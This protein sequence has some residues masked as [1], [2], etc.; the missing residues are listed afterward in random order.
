MAT[1]GI[2]M[3]LRRNLGILQ[4]L[5]VHD[6]ILHVHRIILR[7]NDKSRR[8]LAGYMNI[9]IRRKVLFRERQVAGIDNDGEIGTAA[10]LIRRIVRI[11]KSMLEVS[12]ERGGKMGSRGKSE[13]PDPM[14]INVPL[15]RMRADDPESSLR[16][17]KCG[18][19][20]GIRPRI[21]HAIFHQHASRADRIKPF[22]HLGPFE[23]YGQDVVTAS[24]KDD[25]RGA[26]IGTSWGVNRKRGRRH[27]AQPDKRLAGDQVVF[28]GGRID[29]SSRIRRSA[30]SA[31]RP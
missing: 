30:G 26:G 20:F 27:V 9:R 5:K 10:Y 24:R 4:S 18:R 23:V 8:S 7:L 17:L 22:A 15:A 25:N 29:F 11:V 3:H 13:N 28:G 6:G 14:G 21:R 16:I 19:R 2:E 31:V 1:L 12:A